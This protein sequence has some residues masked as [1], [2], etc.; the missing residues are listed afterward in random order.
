MLM[1]L[2]ILVISLGV[3]LFILESHFLFAF[4]GTLLFGLWMFGGKENLFLILPVGVIFLLIGIFR[5]V[6]NWKWTLGNTFLSLF[7]GA[8]FALQ[9]VQKSSTWH[10]MKSLF[11]QKFQSLPI[12]VMIA[13][14]VSWTVLFYYLRGKQK[15]EWRALRVLDIPATKSTPLSKKARVP[16]ALW[17]WGG[18]FFLIFASVPSWVF[19]FA[20]FLFRIVFESIKLKKVMG[21]FWNFIIPLELLLLFTT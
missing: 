2:F 13:G 15:K 21:L 9:V 1:L 10:D 4:S 12:L 17:F 7:F 16:E 19:L 5:Q 11:L 3:F 18:L 14:V 8:L 6:R 20:F